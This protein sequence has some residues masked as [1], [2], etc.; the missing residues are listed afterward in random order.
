MRFI[1]PITSCSPSIEEGNPE[2]EGPY[3]D[4]SPPD[5]N[6]EMFAPGIVSTGLYKMGIAVSP[7][8]NEIF[9]AMFVKGLEAIVTTRLE[10]GRWT[11][12]EVV[13]FASRFNDGW[14]AFHPNGSKLYLHSSRALD[15]SDSRDSVVSMTR[16]IS[17]YHS[18]AEMTSSTRT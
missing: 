4:Q 18:L 5:L 1:A 2:L 3:L 6:A 16:A 10:N 7:D 15:G 14:P 9:W 11:E 8:G 12:P 17:S 13:P